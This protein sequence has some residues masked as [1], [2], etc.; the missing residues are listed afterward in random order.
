MIYQGLTNLDFTFDFNQVLRQTALRYSTQGNGLI[1]YLIQFN[2][3]T[4]V[5]LELHYGVNKD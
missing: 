1:M 4:G 3:D 2:I 5:A